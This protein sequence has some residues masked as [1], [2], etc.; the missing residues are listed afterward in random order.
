M[1]RGDIHPLVDWDGIHDNE[2]EYEFGYE[3][4]VSFQIDFMLEAAP[5]VLLGGLVVLGNN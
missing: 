1:E 2:S 4:P 5:L 3:K